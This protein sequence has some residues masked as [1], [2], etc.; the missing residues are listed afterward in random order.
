MPV[1]A[2]LPVTVLSLPKSQK[3]SCCNSFRKVVKDLPPLFTAAL[4]I[5]YKGD[6]GLYHI[7]GPAVCTL[8]DTSGIFFR[9]A[10]SIGHIAVHG[11]KWP[12][13]E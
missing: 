10:V 13:G 6:G 11:N 8:P 2:Q 7:S 5:P 12:A 4:L 3:Q 9:F 1:R